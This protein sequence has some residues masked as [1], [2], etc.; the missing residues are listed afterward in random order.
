MPV[1]LV[2][3]IK[4]PLNEVCRHLLV[5]QIAH[6]VD[7][8]S[9]GFLPGH[10]NDQRLGMKRDIKTMGIVLLTHCLEPMGK[11]F[12]VAMLATSTDLGASRNG[13]PSGLRP[14]D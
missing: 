7:K 10:R 2:H 4:H 12:S 5:K 9:L 3:R 6:R 14:F 8:H 11:S 1:S 13:V